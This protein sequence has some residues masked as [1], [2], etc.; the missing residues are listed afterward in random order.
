MKPLMQKIDISFSGTYRSQQGQQPT[1][2]PGPSS[3]QSFGL[4]PLVLAGDEEV[5]EDEVIAQE[6]EDLEEDGMDDARE[7]PEPSALCPHALACPGMVI[8]TDF[9][10]ARVFAPSHA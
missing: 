5:E 3:R 1:D 6:T 7:S 10:L 2:A 4:L 8:Q 9:R